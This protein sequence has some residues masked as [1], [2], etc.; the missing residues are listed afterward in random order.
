MIGV[1]RAFASSCLVVVCCTTVA[2]GQQAADVRPFLAA[3]SATS[4]QRTTAWYRDHF[5]FRI[6]SLDTLSRPGLSAAL[7][8][9][10]GF[11]LEVVAVAGSR[12]RPDALPNS[13]SNASL[14]GLYKLG[15]WVPDAD[16]SALALQQAGVSLYRPVAADS[17]L[18]G[19]V[20]YFLVKD[21]DSTVVQV[22]GPLRRRSE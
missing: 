21:P 20:R 17:S 10:D 1:F 14:Q 2:A 13:A 6:L 12:F 7:L 9:R 16:S 11:Y 5:G 4:V 3:L 18:A 19:G 8:E 22:F 15:F